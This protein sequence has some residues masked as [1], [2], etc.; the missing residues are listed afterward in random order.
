M[1]SS[2]QSGLNYRWLNNG[3]IVANGSLYSSL[4][5]KADTSTFYTVEAT[6]NVENSIINGDF[7]LGNLHFNSD[8]RHT[9]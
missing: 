8:Y 6:V 5:I 7:N 3:Q 4:I 9:S 2:V 1:E